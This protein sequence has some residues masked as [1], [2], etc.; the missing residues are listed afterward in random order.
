MNN[1]EGKIK[2]WIELIQKEQLKSVTEDIQ[3]VVC[4][5]L[6]EKINKHIFKL[7]LY[8]SHTADKCDKENKVIGRELYEL[9]C[10]LCSILIEVPD[11]NKYVSS[12]FHII[13]CLLTMYMF[14]EASDICLYL[15]VECYSHDSMNDVL[16]KIAHL[17]YNSVNNTFCALQK[18]PTVSKH[19]YDLKNIIRYELEMIQIAHKN[20]TK[21]LLMKIS[22]YLDKILAIKREPNAY[23]VDFY[24]FIIEYMNQIE[25]VLDMNEKYIIC[26]HVFHI[27]SRIICENINE[28][29]LKSVTKLL[30]TIN[31][32]FKTLLMEDEECHQCFLLFESMCLI[33]LR[34][35]EY[36]KE[37][38]AKNVQ[39][40]SDNYM[41]I[42]KKYGYQRSIK[43]TTFS[44][45]QI[46]ETLFMY[47]EKCIKTEKKMF[48]KND[49][50]VQMMNLIACISVCF[51]EQISEKCKSCQSENCLIKRDIYNAVVIKIRCI[52]VIS[53]LSA[54][55]LSK[56]ICMFVQRFLEE[57]V[58][59]IYEM[60]KNNCKCWSQ[61]WSTCSALIYNLGIMF[62]CF[63]EESVSLFSL[64]CSSIIR[65]EGI[66]S[67]SH[68]IN[69]QNPIC[70]TLH[71]LSSVHYNH[72]M[73]R[74]AMTSTALN[75]LLSY[76]D[77]DSK[78]FRMWANIKHKSITSK[79]IVEMTI[80]TCLKNDKTKMEELGLSIELSK[81]D[82][83]E[84]C[85]RE[86]GGLQEAKINLSCA[87]Y[88]VLNEMEVLKA[89][90]IQY[91]RAVQMLAYHLLHFDHNE[92]ISECL[93]QVIS[94]LKQIKSNTYVLSLL[95]NLEFYIFITQLNTM[96][97]QTQ[98]EME[99]TKFALYAPK[100]SEIGENESRDVVPVYTKINIREDSKLLLYLQKPLKKWNKCFQKNIKEIANNYESMITLKTLIIAGEYA[101]LHRYQ[102]CEIN[103]WNLAYALASELKNNYAIIYVVG[104]SISVRHINLEW[105]SIGKKLA[106]E[107]KDS[108]DEDII[109]AVAIFWISLSDFYF[110]CNMYTEARTL[111]NESRKL[112][113]ISFFR[114]I[115]VYLY[116][117]D[118]ILYNCYL[119]Q[120]SIKHEEYTRYIVETLYTLVNLNEELST[121]K[122][123]HQDKHLF[124]FDILLSSTINLSL[125]MN[126]LLSFREIGAHLVRRLKTAQ[127][128]GAIA[129]V[130]EI[131]K[132]LCYIDLSRSQLSDCEVKLQ[133]LEHMLNI[134]TFKVSMNTKSTKMVSENVLLT[135][136]Q[137]IDPIRDIPQNDASPILRNKVFDLPE[138]M[139]HKGCD[140]YI[141][142]NIS[143]QYLV[144]SST[145][146]R[147]QL[148]ALQKN[149]TASLQHFHGAFKIK[150][151]LMKLEKRTSKNENQ[152]ISWQER[153]YSVDYVLLLINFTYFLKNYL[154][155]KQEKILNIISIAIQICD[156]YK[157]I[158][159]PIYMTVKE[160]LIDHRFLQSVNSSVSSTFTVPDLA[161]I[162]ISAF[163]H[164]STKEENICVTPVN[165]NIRIKKPITLQRNRT[166]PLLKLTKVSM[167]FS[168]DEDNNSSPPP[169]EL[170]RTR[171]RSKLIRRK[172]LDEEYL[173]PAENAKE[174]QSNLSL[175][176]H[177]I[178]NVSI[179]DIVIKVTSVI[180]DISEYL[181][182][183][184]NEMDEP[185]TEKS[186]QKLIDIIENYKMNIIS[187]RCTRRVRHSKQ[188]TS[189]DYNKINQAIALFKDL[190][191]N[192]KQDNVN[193]SN[194]NNVTSAS[195]S[196]QK[197]CRITEE[198]STE[199]FGQSN[200]IDKIDN[201][202]KA[203]VNEITRLKIIR[204]STKNN[205]KN[206]EMHTMRTRKSKET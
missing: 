130:A 80:I 40:F 127:T 184:V 116:I 16:I 193:L 17:W 121:K 162:D 201:L 78:A 93:E 115:A 191:I 85:L 6:S 69:L 177:K 141:C 118:R 45:V 96:N 62:D 150:E 171:S 175:K 19:Y 161:D 83:V 139:R 112:P 148:Y 8:L 91:A 151:N 30:N 163:V 44:I 72:G 67:K 145:H 74:E 57:N 153:F 159:H 53:K 47:W 155:S 140:C 27:I 144:F 152:Y 170:R 206:M 39:D 18:S 3:A 14:K 59:A 61:L 50:L 70:F 65:F 86:V 164:K 134:E 138:F 157:L 203:P 117:L 23:F 56:D 180:P 154:H 189:S 149:T 84:I 200:K 68:Y 34:P 54:S 194:K 188:L 196:C 132:A 33:L 133:G 120:Q 76:D 181:H 131:L 99:N 143:Y 136:V 179:R 101:R 10:L 137:V 186:I 58:A 110:E 82:L 26:R 176:E 4:T 71:R 51:T 147:A 205:I 123:R 13:R 94:R 160:L 113:G 125:R 43:W 11:S 75:A 111:L 124:G 29:C 187:Q 204:N 182:K 12:L 35:V 158:G 46:L 109:Y 106:N 87:I 15:K 41:T 36:L 185:A 174:P 156:M 63:Y 108:Q 103:L 64:L 22:S 52:N 25:L 79:E 38:T 142:K 135:P 20:F 126:S 169:T 92:D 190:A 119:Y 114:N 168:D 195:I 32:N 199:K 49:I 165:S 9:T 129:R 146:I 21:Y 97:K 166:P 122:W 107:L 66:H 102:E 37:C 183:T 77:P 42:V 178:N 2:R 167:N 202:K 89:T 105:I 5:N 100:M 1:I 128:L 73:Y 90:P 28:K 55:D 173:D 88:Q 60:M 98:I 95:A 198:S 104:R 192:D 48:L 81:Y 31:N 197:Q 24:T 7:L 172:I